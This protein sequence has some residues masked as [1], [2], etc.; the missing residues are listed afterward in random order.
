MRSFRARGLRRA[1]PDVQRCE[2]AGGSRRE[3]VSWAQRWT[4]GYEAK[5][6]GGSLGVTE[7]GQQVHA[8]AHTVVA[9]GGLCLGAGL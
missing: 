8:V 5:G 3:D 2:A 1:H 9:T 6:L 4:R 7:G